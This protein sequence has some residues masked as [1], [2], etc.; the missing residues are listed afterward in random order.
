MRELIA[1]RFEVSMSLASI[2]TLLDRI[3]LPPQKPLQQACQQDPEAIVHWQK[4]TYP[5]IVR[6]AKRDKAVLDR[7]GS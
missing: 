5:A 7:Y 6:K 3:S 2:G 4:E 1:Q